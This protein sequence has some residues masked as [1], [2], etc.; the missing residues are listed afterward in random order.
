V[1]DS[2]WFSV[3]WGQYAAAAALA[4]PGGLGE[5]FRED[6]VN[7]RFRASLQDAPEFLRAL[8]LVAVA[9][10][11]STRYS[12]DFRTGRNAFSG[13]GMMAWE[14]DEAIRAETEGRER[15]RDLL[16]R[17]LAEDPSVPLDL[18][19]LPDLCRQA[20]GVDVPPIYQRWLGP[21]A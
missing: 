18:D 6:L 5:S 21:L 17:L 14:M 11:A 2:I 8:P 13:G 15:L 20:T 7:R 4:G 1:I 19:R 16:L 9:C 10:I 3:G 12:E